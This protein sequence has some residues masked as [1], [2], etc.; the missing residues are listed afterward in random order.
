MNQP[1]LPS[2]GIAEAESAT[3]T[4]ATKRF[5]HLVKVSV[6]SVVGGGVVGAIVSKRRGRGALIGVALG[7]VFTRV[8]GILKKSYD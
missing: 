3:E 4:K 5:N 6:I 7:L 1:T 8:Y 2:D